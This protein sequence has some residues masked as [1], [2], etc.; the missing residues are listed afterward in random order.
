MAFFEALRDRAVNTINQVLDNKKSDLGLS[1]DER[2][3][4]E[5]N[6][7]DGEV[8]LDETAAEIG[9]KHERVQPQAQSQS[10]SQAHGN[11]RP[12]SNSS[13]NQLDILPQGRLYLTP[14]FLVFRDAFDRKA[15]SFTLHLS[16]IKKVERLPTRSYVYALSTTTHSRLIITFY[17]VGVRPES[18]KFAHNLKLSLRANLPN[19]SKLQPFIQTLYSE[20]LLSKNNVSL[21]KVEEVPPGGLGLKF[22]FPG[23]AKDSRDKSKMKLWFDLL[24]TDGRNLSVIK[25]PMFYRLVR[26]GL[27]NRLRGEIWELCCGSMYYRLDNPDEYSKIL[28]VNEGKQSLAKEEIEKDLNRS[29]PEYV[30]Y[31]SPEGIERLR[32][33]LTAYSWK[34]PDVGYCQAMN[35]VVAALLIYM[36]EEQAF[37]CLN[38]LCDRIVPGYYSKTMYG[39]LL[40]QRVFESLVQETMP[41]LWE[42]ITKYDIQLSVVSLPWF[43]SLYLSSM[44]LVFAFRII[45]VFFL[46]GPKTL[47]QVALAIIK[48]NGEELLKT[49]DDGTFIQILKNYFQTLDQSAHPNSPNEKYRAITKFQELLVTAFKEFSVIDE[50]AINKH[51][52]KHRDTIFQNI[53]TFVKRTELRNLPKTAF[54]Q[55]ALSIIY[56]RFYSMVESYN[57][58]MASG[59]SLMDFKAFTKFMSEICDWCY[60]YEDGD[61]E[62]GSAGELSNPIETSF[63]KRLFNHWDTEDQGAI[64]LSDLVV[65]LNRLTAPD[66]MENMA[67][68]FELYDHKGN[69][70]IDREGILQMSEDLL[71]ITTPWKEASLLDS[72]TE[73]DIEQVIADQI[74]KQKKQQGSDTEGEIIVPSE[75]DIDDNEKQRLIN[76]QVERYLSGASTF[77]QRAFEYAQP[78]EEEVLLEELSITDNKI[79]HNAALNPNA[80]V[81]INLPTFRMVVLADETYE[82]L[83]SKT[84]SSSIHVDKPLDSKFKTIRNLRDMFDGLLADGRKVA[85]QVRRRMDS[86]A[87]NAKHNSGNN[88][89]PDSASLKS[90]KKEE[91]EYRDDDF[92]VIAIDEKDKDLLLGAEAQ[93]LTDPVRHKTTGSSSDISK[94]HKA[95]AEAEAASHSP[96]ETN[97]IEF[98]HD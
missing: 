19:V 34:N 72:I 15:C 56:D 61:S 91:E 1:K 49:E 83:F 92:G 8:I 84:F 36:S 35:I 5:Y 30:A 42:H 86:A 65:G 18:E 96:R 37:W 74:V 95:E 28:Q 25:T 3:C 40:D 44:P 32:R 79:S 17:L 75:I 64:T 55:E 69:G 52:A 20:Y 90:A 7:P 85:T 13:A 12:H 87:S 54:T 53:S 4:R 29:L 46:Q 58:T 45:D 47:F 33:V 93:V 11:N 82:L 22:K 63:L 27:P 38:V 88:S 23:N 16:T 43:L 97:L 73:R 94:F 48:L 9:I 70:K 62:K 51:R 39:T 6:L 21:E 98:E 57:V 41:I 78:Q 80:P 89:S 68:F 71:Y 77:I 14:H 2:F 66:L 50:D 59:S 10:Q 60:A 31:Q 67:N 24:R 76:Q 26:V 81:Y